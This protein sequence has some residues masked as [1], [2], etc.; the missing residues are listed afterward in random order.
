MHGGSSY[1][2]RRRRPKLPSR[3]AAENGV[4][5]AASRDHGAVAI[6]ERA[7][8]LTVKSRPSRART[9]ARSSHRQASPSAGPVVGSVVTTTLRFCLPRNRQPCSEAQEIGPR[10]AARGVP[11]PVNEA[12]RCASVHTILVRGGGLDGRRELGPPDIARLGLRLDKPLNAPRPLADEEPERSHLQLPDHRPGLRTRPGACLQLT[13]G[14]E[15]E[16]TAAVVPQLAAHEAP[17]VALRKVDAP[18]REV[19]LGPTMAQPGNGGGDAIGWGKPRRAVI[20]SEVKRD[21]H[22]IPILH[23]PRFACW[24]RL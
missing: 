23:Q 4:P 9:V 20:R 22:D 24:Q 3:A 2:R 16:V 5:S 17:P 14:N 12:C 6:T 15:L 21:A 11:E 8:V 1:D 18:H 10:D 7:S 19:R 13:N